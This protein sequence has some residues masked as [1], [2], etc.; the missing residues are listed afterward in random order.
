MI[1]PVNELYKQG[2]QVSPPFLFS[3]SGVRTAK[4]VLLNK[5][6]LLKIKQQK[7]S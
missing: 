6:S 5:P 7:I 3:I 1:N 2:G 4:P